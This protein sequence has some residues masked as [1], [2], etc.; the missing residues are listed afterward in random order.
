MRVAILGNS[1]SGKSTLARNL[2][3][4]TG[5][6]AVDLDTFAWEPG[7]VAVPRDPALAAAEVAAFCATHQAWI[8]EGCYAELI[9]ATLP[10]R[11][12]LVFLEPGVE[13]CLA[14]CRAPDGRPYAASDPDLLDWV[15]AYYTREGDL[16]LAAHQALFEAYEGPKQ[17]LTAEPDEACVAALAQTGA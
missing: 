17:K 1:G 5:T 16:S 4:R 12:T 3:T 8:I 9:R 2:A 10:H 14:H 15:R 11:P 13:A 7:Q 6:P